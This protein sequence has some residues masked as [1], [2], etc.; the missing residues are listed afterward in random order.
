MGPFQTVNDEQFAYIAFTLS[1]ARK[2]PYSSDFLNSFPW[3]SIQWYTANINSDEL[4]NFYLFWDGTAWGQGPTPPRRLL[5][6]TQDFMKMAGDFSK[7]NFEHFIDILKWRD[8]YRCGYN[9]ERP[10]L[11]LV[12]SGVDGP[13]MILDGNHRAVAGVW[14]AIES[15]QW[16]HMPQLIYV[17]ISGAMTSYP[18]Y[19]RVKN[20]VDQGNE[21][22]TTWL[23]KMLRWAFVRLRSH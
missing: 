6:G 23:F 18:F 7:P 14:W 12:S 2:R 21:E 11:I 15:Q 10:F 4:K 1:D 20:G 9:D 16:Q 19:N 8:R 3:T 13:F 22:I 5:Q 17:G